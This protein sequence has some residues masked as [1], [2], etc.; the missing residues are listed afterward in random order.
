MRICCIKCPAFGGNIVATIV[1][2]DCRPQM[3]TV[4]EGVMKKEIRDENYTGKTIRLNV[5]KYVDD[6]DF[7]IGVIERH[8][9]KSKINLK[10]SPIIVAGGYGMGSAEN[11]NMLFDLARV[12]GGEV[13]AS[14]AAVDAGFS[15][16]ARQNWATANSS[17][18]SYTFAASRSSNTLPAYRECH[19]HCHQ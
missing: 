5:S 1:N 12:L 7:V 2:P 17:T 9:E 18:Q 19:D 15:E 10:A 16:H 13:G 6:A 14:R 11:F 4:R 3:A 8:M